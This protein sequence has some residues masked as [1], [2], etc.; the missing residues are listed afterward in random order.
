MFLSKILSGTV[1]MDMLLQF[2]LTQLLTQFRLYAETDSTFDQSTESHKL[3]RLVRP[4]LWV[5][6][7]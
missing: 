1:N 3:L 4:V 7:L 5:A 6:A 2:V